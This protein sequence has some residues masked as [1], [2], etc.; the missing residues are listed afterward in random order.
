M[1]T[2]RETRDLSRTA[3]ALRVF[4][5]FDARF[6]KRVL[7]TRNQ[8]ALNRLDAEH[9]RLSREVGVAFGRDTDRAIGGPND[10]EVCA[11]LIRPGPIVP[12]LGMEESFVRRMVRLWREERQSRIGK[13]DPAAS[14]SGQNLPKT[15]A[16]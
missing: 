14:S 11:D 6:R 10:P 5:E 16:P 9:E 13:S 8:A 1:S 4:D 15:P 7:A 3:E 12:P 2:W